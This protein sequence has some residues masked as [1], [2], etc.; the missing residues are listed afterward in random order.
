MCLLPSCCSYNVWYNDCWRDANPWRIVKSSLNAVFFRSH[1]AARERNYCKRKVAPCFGYNASH[2][3]KPLNVS[4]C[5][6]MKHF[7]EFLYHLA[8]TPLRHFDVLTNVTHAIVNQPAFSSWYHVL[9]ISTTKH[10]SNSS[11]N[12]SASWS[13][14]LPFSTPEYDFL[15]H[16]VPQ[17]YPIKQHHTWTQSLS[18]ASPEPD[19]RSSFKVHHLPTPASDSSGIQK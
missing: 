18:Y 1:P 16:A 19:F 14:D 17:S 13:G 9:Q 6:R 7:N 4:N 11:K 12:I 15:F 3:S 8:L 5:V 2:W 10:I